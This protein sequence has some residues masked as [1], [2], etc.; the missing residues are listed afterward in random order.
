MC[1]EESG[2][3]RAYGAGLLSGCQE[4]QY[5]LTDKPNHKVFDID[6]ALVTKYPETGLQPLY[7]VV[8]SLDD[9]KNKM[10]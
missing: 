1:K 9:M 7:F 8:N 3:L 4:L 10:V 2:E 6:N 5:C